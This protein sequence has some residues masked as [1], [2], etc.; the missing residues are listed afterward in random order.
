[1][2]IFKSIHDADFQINPRC[3]FSLHPH[4]LLSSHPRLFS[5]PS[6]HFFLLCDKV[7]KAI[8]ISIQR[9]SFKTCCT[10]AHLNTGNYIVKSCCLCMWLKT[11]S[12]SNSR[13]L[14]RDWSNCSLSHAAGISTAPPKNLSLPIIFAFS[15]SSQTTF[16]SQSQSI[17]RSQVPPHQIS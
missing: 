11:V 9:K 3:K 14:T 8:N 1:M 6:S 4:L 2:Q 16:L 13:N 7:L 15:R 10:R 12:A 5:T 17:G